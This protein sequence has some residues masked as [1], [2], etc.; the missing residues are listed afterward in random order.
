MNSINQSIRLTIATIKQK[1]LVKT[2]KMLLLRVFVPH[3]FAPY[4]CGRPQE[5]GVCEETKRI[6]L[7]LLKCKL[8][9]YNF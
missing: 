9:K 5:E 2:R 8:C 4:L 6:S 3:W 1:K 7:Y